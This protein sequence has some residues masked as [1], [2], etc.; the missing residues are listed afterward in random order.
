MLRRPF[1]KKYWLVSAAALMIAFS[2]MVMASSGEHD[3]HHATTKTW[4]STDTYRVM[5]FL[6]LV[7]GLFLILKKPAS[8][9]LNARIST[10]KDELEKLESEKSD[11]EKK[12]AEYN[13][14]FSE[15]EKEAQQL[16]SDY[17]QQ[18]KSAQ[19]RIIEDA[20]LTAEKMQAQAK[21]NIEQEFRI[22]NKILKEEIME[23]SI[24]L[25]ENVIKDNITKDDQDRLIGEFSEK[26]VA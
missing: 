9:A 13:Q 5:N 12:L 10:I 8:Q 15:L 11:A 20:K 3:E 24:A 14:K 16:V 25:A 19:E 26:V 17:I 22:A 21:K 7:V 6:V 23:K 2:G 18:G 1:T 4:V